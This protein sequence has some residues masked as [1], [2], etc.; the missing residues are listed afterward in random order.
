MIPTLLFSLVE[1]LL[2]LPCH[3]SHWKGERRLSGRSISA[4]FLRFQTWFA[5]RLGAFIHGVYQPILAAALWARYL[6]IS[7]AIGV[8]IVTMG[9][10]VG[11]WIK[12][13]FFPPVEGDN[14]TQLVGRCRDLAFASRRGQQS[15]WIA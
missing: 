15:R 4:V 1:S 6:T 10:I 7:V 14:M 5:G 2:V 9:L 8:M 11:G 12:F 13:Q 3:L